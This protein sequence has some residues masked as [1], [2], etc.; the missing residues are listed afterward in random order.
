MANSNIT[1]YM[2]HGVGIPNPMWRWN[3]LT[4]PYQVFEKQLKALRRLNYYTPTLDEIYDHINGIKLL[5]VIN[6]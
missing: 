5:L 4:C 6:T 1:I 3:Y 2:Y